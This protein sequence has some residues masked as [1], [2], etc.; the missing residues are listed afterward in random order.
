[1]RMERGRV[2]E[3]DST[4]DAVV[5]GS[6]P[7]GL[8]AAIALAQ[9]GKSVVVVEAADRPGGGTRSAAL[10]LPGYL[11]DVCSA[12]H[13]LGVASPF[14]AS[15]PLADHGL[16]WVQPDAPVAHPLP[17]GSAAILERSL[18][19]MVA[20]LGRPDGRAW[21]R[22]VGPLVR[23]WD[24]VL[25]SVLGPLIRFPPHPVTMARF[26]VRAAW[27]AVAL[28]KALFRDEAARAVFAGLA[29][30]AILDLRMPLTGSFG[31]L[32]AASAH[33][34][35]WPAARRGS[36]AIA[37]ALVSYLGTLGG[38]VVCGHPVRTLADLPPA[39]VALFDV[40]PRQLVA[41]AGDRLAPGMRRRLG[42]YRYG[43]GSFKVDYALDGPVPWK[44]EE[45]ARAASVHVCGTL[46]DVARAEA[47]VAR[48]RHP[49]QPF[50]LCTQPG[51]FDDTRAPAGRQSFWAYCHVPHGSDVD[52]TGAIEDQLE[53]FAPGFRDRVL[54]RHVM[55]PAAIEAYNA[56]CVGGDIAGGSHGGL[57]LIGRPRLSLRPYRVAVD[58][59][60]T[61]LCSSSTP[62]G[63]GVHGMCGWWAARAALR[64]VFGARIG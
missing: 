24:K 42:R 19:A 4:V 37:D 44:A 58:G 34:A 23:N 20:S 56:N 39:R 29:G 62:P 50:V 60:P 53:R 25:A 45:C 12:I 48:G 11:H 63:A 61:Y 59:L 54:A 36:Q 16:A 64:D 14:F 8:A 31:V 33:A 7:N 5:V 10:T 9:A 49:D 32:F 18:D 55:G 43:P 52:M 6:G 17:D 28:A 51:L 38:E 21:R 35:G 30:H 47:E 27:P 15:L 46:D 57:Q 1:M 2:A 26:G 3:T 41:I 22:L 13:P 40:T